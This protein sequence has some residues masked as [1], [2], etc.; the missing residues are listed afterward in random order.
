MFVFVVIAGGLKQAEIVVV[1]NVQG[2]TQGGSGIETKCV[3]LKP[4][5]EKKDAPLR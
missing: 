4:S 5:G 3:R 1:R 2:L